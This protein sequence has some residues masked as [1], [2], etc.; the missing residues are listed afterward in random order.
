MKRKKVIE[1]SVERNS[2]E[3]ARSIIE[4]GVNWKFRKENGHEKYKMWS[5]QTTQWI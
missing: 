5:K 4:Q 2:I 3:S 1:T